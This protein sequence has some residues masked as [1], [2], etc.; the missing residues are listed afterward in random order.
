MDA[1]QKVNVIQGDVERKA[2]KDT[3]HPWYDSD[4]KEREIKFREAYIIERND[5]DKGIVDCIYQIK[6]RTFTDLSFARGETLARYPDLWELRQHMDGTKFLFNYSRIP[7]FDESDWIWDNT[8]YLVVYWDGDEA[9]LISCRHGVKIPRIKIYI[10]LE[11][12]N[13]NFDRWLAILKNG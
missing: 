2:L 8:S 5:W 3:A 12:S 1:E 13:P 6:G 10:G 7:T 4:T 11:K 9:V